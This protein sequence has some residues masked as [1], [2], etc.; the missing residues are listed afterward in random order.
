MIL[1]T[2]GIGARPFV[3]LQ[4]AHRGATHQHQL[5]DAEAVYQLLLHFDEV[6]QADD[7][8]AEP[9]GLARI[10]IDRGRPRGRHVR[11][12]HVEVHEGVGRQDKELVGV[13]RLAG[14]DDRI[15]VARHFLGFRVFA[16]GVRGAGE[17]VADQD[18]VGLVRI[19][20]AVA[21]PAHL[22]VLERAPRLGRER[23]QLEHLLLGDQ[24][25][26]RGWH[27]SQHQ[28]DRKRD[29]ARHAFLPSGSRVL[30]D[31]D[32]IAGRV[33][34]NPDALWAGASWAG[35]GLPTGMRC[36]RRL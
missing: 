14:A 28:Q 11:V 22:H 1:P 32:V 34:A 9:V 36:V 33:P 23:R 6:A 27:Q 13:D 18:G 31:A 5:L 17:K 4:A 29:Q 30:R 21:L 26:R 24:V 7:G 35:R 19:E 20:R 3:G 12:G 10:G 25:L 8:E 16:G 2:I 15:P